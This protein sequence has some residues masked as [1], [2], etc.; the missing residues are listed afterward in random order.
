MKRSFASYL[1]GWFSSVR[2]AFRTQAGRNIAIYAVCL[3]V[4]F[5]F[6]VMMTLDEPAKR[7]YDVK[8]KLTNVPDSVVVCDEMSPSVSVV[9]KGKGLN[10]VRNDI[11][12]V[13]VM[14]I[15]FRQYSNKNGY[16]TVS[17]A[18]LDRKL[19]ELFGSGVTILTIN[20]DTL[21]LSYTIGAA[22]DSR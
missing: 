16:I 4:A 14:E 8:Y 10:F 6:W 7:E 3:V 17:R 18:K 5:L 9:V 11:L 20:P 21:R 2:K 13:P 22:D 19:R 15:D 12:G 1:K